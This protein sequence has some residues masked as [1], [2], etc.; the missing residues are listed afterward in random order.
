MERE[1]YDF[2]SCVSA[3]RGISLRVIE[4][5]GPNPWHLVIRIGAR[6]LQSFARPKLQ[7]ISTYIDLSLR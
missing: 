6:N 3:G 5:L 2:H 4:I 1:G 7:H